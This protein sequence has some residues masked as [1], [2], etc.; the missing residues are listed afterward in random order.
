MAWDC[1]Q[2][3]SWADV[4]PDLCLETIIFYKY[5]NKYTQKTKI[6]CS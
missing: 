2:A 1:Q 6:L 5:I 4:G 3:I